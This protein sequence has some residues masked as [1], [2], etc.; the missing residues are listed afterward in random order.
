MV[1]DTVFFTS[2]HVSCNGP[3]INCIQVAKQ[4]KTV[5]VEVR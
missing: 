4:M 5:F 2:V 3:V 1:T